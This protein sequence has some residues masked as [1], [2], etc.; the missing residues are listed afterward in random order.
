MTRTFLPPSS[1]GLFRCFII[2]IFLFAS[3]VVSGETLP[4]KGSFGF[5]GG[6][7]VASLGGDFEDIGRILASELEG[8]VG[9]DW[10]SS[11][12]SLS[13]P[14]LGVYY[15]FNLSATF[16]LQLEGQYIR[17]G[18]GLE[19]RGTS[20]PTVGALDMEVGFKLSYIEFPLLVRYKGNPTAK[21]RPVLLGG[22]VIGFKVAASMELSAQGEN[23]SQDISDGVNSTMFGLLGGVGLAIDVGKT[24]ALVF[25]GRYY[26]GLTEPIDDADFS[27]KSG[28]FGFFVGLEFAL[29][30]KGDSPEVTSESDSLPR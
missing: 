20:V 21:V 27:A 1:Q 17:R 24:T 26:L 29:G 3:S 23:V 10:T 18:G 14:G 2:L 7:N 15:L 25:Q 22:P 6:L 19:L 16:G 12:S 13:N 4:S 5:F 30:P 8:E 28:D 11:T 9:G